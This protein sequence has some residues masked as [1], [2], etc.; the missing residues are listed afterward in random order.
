MVTR[1]VAHIVTGLG[2]GGAER[3]LHLLLRGMD[4]VRCT[5]MVLVRHASERDHWTSRIRDLQVPLVGL[6]GAQS[7]IRRLL[8]LCR[9]IRAWR[10]D[11]LQGWT[12]R[13][14]PRL[15]VLG[16]LCRVPVRL[17]SLRCSL[18]WQGGERGS[19]G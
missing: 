8:G 15:A 14:T 12:L 7:Q 19:G 4:R 18:Y 2:Q 1:K 10:P 13:T 16:R 11:I 17:G 5:P 6:S 9:Q 3:Q